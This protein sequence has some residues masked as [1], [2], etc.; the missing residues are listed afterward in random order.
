MDKV[1][2]LG[3]PHVA[4]TI[5]GYLSDC[6]LLECSKV[7]ET[8]KYVSEKVSYFRWKNQVLEQMKNS[9][10]TCQWSGC[11]QY[12]LTQEKLEE[13]LERDHIKEDT[14]VCKWK[15]CQREGSAFLE[16]YLLVVHMRSHIFKEGRFV[17]QWKD[18]HREGR[19]F[20]QQYM[21]VVHMR[22]H[23]QKAS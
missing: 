9:E 1:I 17:C 12:F 10:T 18:C 11:Q 5:L 16:R 19:A 15:N 20:N 2:N 4:E 22:R 23:T 7:S 14:R 3:I 13:H 6:Q 21:L 8:W